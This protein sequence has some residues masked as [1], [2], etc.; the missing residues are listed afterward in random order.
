MRILLHYHAVFEG[1]RLAFIGIA[2]QVARLVVLG[3]KAPLHTRGETRST[4]PAQSRFLYHLDQIVG[5]VLFERPGK[6]LIAAMLPV[7]IQRIQ[8]RG[9][10]I[11]CDDKFWH[12]V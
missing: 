12:K 2:A 9:I 7:S 11:F 5:L 6:R 1:T 4:A 3:K 10:Y 8:A